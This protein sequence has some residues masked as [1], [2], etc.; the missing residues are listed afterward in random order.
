MVAT[1][2]HSHG[3]LA[4]VRRPIAGCLLAV[5]AAGVMSLTV[6]APGASAHQRR[7]R[8]AE[9][10]IAGAPRAQLRRAVLC[11]INHQRRARHLPRLAASAR[12]DRSAQSWTGVMVDHGEF[13]HGAAF[14]DRI[15]AVGF[16]WSNVAEDIATG[17]ATPSAVVRAW[18]AS[19]GHCANIL[20]PIYREVGTGVSDH[21]I[22]GA[23]TIDGTWTQDFG[24]I[25]GQHAA[26][27]N[28]GPARSCAHR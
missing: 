20:S 25:M 15:S 2:S 23:S 24:L 16:D 7:C 1:A 28:W 4:G 8:H 12:L 19:P 27:G 18:M 10:S 9:T 14:M 5:A 13:S 26:S 11:L 21:M 17:Y 22:S 3:P 6:M